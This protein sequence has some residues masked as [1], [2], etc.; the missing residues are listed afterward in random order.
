MARGLLRLAAY[1]GDSRYDDA[2]HDSLRL[3][4]EA[5]RHYPQAFGEALNAVDMLVAGQDEVAIV[6]DPATEM[7]RAL[8]KIV[9][10]PYRPNVITALANADVPGDHT[11]PL[12][13]YR[14]MRGG[15]PTVYVCRNFAC[16]MPVTTA[17]E[18]QRL[19]TYI[20]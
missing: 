9:R 5:M 7:T 11:I 16:A 12:L 20:T 4:T 19:L 3:L 14:V 17:G 18:V 15:Q 2:A 13:S 8:L 6:G 1:T 10:E